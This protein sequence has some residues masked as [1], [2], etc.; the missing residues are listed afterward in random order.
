MPCSIRIFTF[1]AKLISSWI[2]L[3]LVW[4]L[5]LELLATLGYILRWSTSRNAT[6]SP[7]KRWS[8]FPNDVRCPMFEKDLKLKAHSST[9]LGIDDVIVLPIDV[10]R[11]HKQDSMC[12]SSQAMKEEEETTAVRLFAWWRSYARRPTD[13]V[14]T[15]TLKS[16]NTWNFFPTAANP[17]KSQQNGNTATVTC[18]KGF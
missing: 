1:L 8:C 6:S 10:R 5:W 13:D 18:E 2:F 7:R 9:C 17:S 12:C 15:E 11:G 14:E 3:L 16:W 4:V